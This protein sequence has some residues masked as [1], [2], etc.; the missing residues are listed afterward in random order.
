MQRKNVREIDR[1]LYRDG[2]KKQCGF[3]WFIRGDDKIRANKLNFK[4]IKA[5]L[6]RYSIEIKRTFV[7]LK[8]LVDTS[9]LFYYYLRKLRAST[10]LLVRSITIIVPKAHEIIIEIN[11]YLLGLPWVFGYRLTVQ[12]LVD[13]EAPVHGHGCEI[14]PSMGDLPCCRWLLA[15][16]SLKNA[17]S[18]GYKRN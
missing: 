11:L 8:C 13:S 4:L 12:L 3:F 7:T 15:F 2:R 16:P 1:T 9:V 17:N 6:W 5:M 18:N 14:V 10:R